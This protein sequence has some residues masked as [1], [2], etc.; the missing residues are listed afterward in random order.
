MSVGLTASPVAPS[1]VRRRGQYMRRNA[2]LLTLAF[3]SAGCATTPI[4]VPVAVITGGHILRGENTASLSSASFSVTDGKL[5][6]VGSYDPLNT[7]RTITVAVTCNDGRTGIAIA[8]RDS[9]I[10]GGGKVTLS[11]GSEGTFIFG[12]AARKI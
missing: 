1:I 3:G 12:D 6:C 9:P 10:S 7:S 4:T 2:L 8:T 5:T 11:D